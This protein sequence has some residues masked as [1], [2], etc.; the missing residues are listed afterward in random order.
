MSEDNTTQGPLTLAIDIGGS[1]LKMLVLDAS[2]EPVTERTRVPTP[3]PALPAPVLDALVS[4]FGDHGRFDRVSVGFPGVVVD[5]VTKNA[6]NLDPSWAGFDLAAALTE[7]AGRPTRVANDADVQGFGAIEGR[8]VEERLQSDASLALPKA[9]TFDPTRGEFRSRCET[10][11]S[12]HR[13][14]RI[15]AA[16]DG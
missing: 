1:G 10:G 14:E 9:A 6:P 4:Q 7:R 13:G 2:G 5:G 8:G 16:S 11:R 15:F 3:R 12:D